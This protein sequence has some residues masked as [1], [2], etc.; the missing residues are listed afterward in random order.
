MGGIGRKRAFFVRR[1]CRSWVVAV[2]ESVGYCI[3]VV[4][5]YESVL[6]I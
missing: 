6:W 5:C 3:G 2:D 4:G 1:K